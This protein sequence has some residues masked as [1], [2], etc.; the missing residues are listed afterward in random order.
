LREL[1]SNTLTDSR[2]TATKHSIHTEISG[3][4]NNPVTGNSHSASDFD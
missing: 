2:A 1:N 3:V 4:T